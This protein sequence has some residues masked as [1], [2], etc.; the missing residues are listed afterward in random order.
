MSNLV[1]KGK[2]TFHRDAVGKGDYGKVF[3]GRFE[4]AVD[5]TIVR[6]DKSEFHMNTKIL[7]QTDLHPNIVRFY[8][9]V[10][11]DEFQ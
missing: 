8:G 4:D 9:A 3:D 10:E 11:D 6:V 5:V 2:L 7:R 1:N